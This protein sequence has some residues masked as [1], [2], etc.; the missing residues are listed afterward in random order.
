ML[1]LVGRVRVG[2]R[3]TGRG[4]IFIIS[5]K[6]TGTTNATARGKMASLGGYPHLT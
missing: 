6:L 1:N 4:Y 5:I 3:S 2:K